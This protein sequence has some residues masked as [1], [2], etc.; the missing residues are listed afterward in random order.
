MKESL[1]AHFLQAL[2]AR[3]DMLETEHVVA[4]RLF[5]GFYEGIPELVV[6]LYA[7]TLVLFNYGKESSPPNNMLADAQSILLDAY[8]WVETVIHKK[9]YVR[10][11]ALRKGVITFGKSPAQQISEFDV[12]YALD[13]LINQDASF[14]LDTRNLRRWLLDHAA[15][16]QVLNMFAYTGSL[17]VAALAAG[18]NRVVQGDRSR[19]FLAMARQSAM[20]NRLD[21]GKMK[22]SAVDF[23]RQIS[24]LKTSGDLFDC[25]I[26]DPPF[27]ST[28]SKGKVDQVN[29]SVRLINKVRPLIRDGGYLVAINNALF[30]SGADY[31]G[32][33]EKLCADGY[34]SVETLI[35][36]PLDM[37]GYPHTIVNPAPSDP[38]PFNHPT[39]IAVLRVRR[40]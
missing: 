11:L 32:S 28:T 15:G 7:R 2:S 16:W 39:K 21:L 35:P 19:K 33:L 25:V 37:T 4:L 20:L 1:K 29:E 22:T 9:R 18:A 30:L 5:N 17:G 40:R 23:F 27:F 3:T 31:M 14:Y 13:L 12:H 24:Q 36:I 34:L 8:P 38:A 26:L 10:D 6:D